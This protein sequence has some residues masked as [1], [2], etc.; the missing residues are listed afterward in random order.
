MLGDRALRLFQ[1]RLRLPDLD[2]YAARVLQ[3]L[4]DQ[5][6]QLGEAVRSLDALRVQVQA[7]VILR[8]TG[9]ERRQPIDE[10]RDHRPHRVLRL[11]E[12]VLQYT[13]LERD[14]AQA[15]LDLGDRRTVERSVGEQRDDLHLPAHPRILAEQLGD[16]R[17]EQPQDAQEALVDL[18]HV[19]P[20]RVQR[21]PELLQPRGKSDDVLGTRRAVAEGCRLACERLCIELQIGQMH[22]LRNDGLPQCLGEQLAPRMRDR[23]YADRLVVR[24]NTALDF[25]PDELVVLRGRRKPARG[26]AAQRL[27]RDHRKRLGCAT[28]DCGSL[29]VRVHA[30]YR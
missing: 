25:L 26:N 24:G 12:A 27:A 13:L 30:S 4:D 28:R 11:L 9:G 8:R 1:L 3:H 10:R 29:R 22:E 14:L 16:V 19:G 20:T 2:L 6:G 23:R 21:E 15:P 17:G 5:G 7:L 18:V